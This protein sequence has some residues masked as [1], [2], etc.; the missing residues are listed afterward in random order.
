MKVANGRPGPNIFAG[1]LIREGRTRRV[2]SRIQ[3]A[4]CYQTYLILAFFAN[5]PDRQ[6]TMR[7][8]ELGRSFV[9]VDGH[10]VIKY[11]PNDY[12]TGKVYG[13]RPLLKLPE[14]LTP[15]I[16]HC[17]ENW[18]QRTRQKDESALVAGYDCHP[19]SQPARERTR[20]GIFGPAHGMLGSDSGPILRS[21]DANAKGSARGGAVGINEP[22][23]VIGK[24]RDCA[25]RPRAAPKGPLS[26]S[27]LPQRLSCRQR[28]F[29]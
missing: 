22:S 1:C 13:E 8:L 21:T 18:R 9:K 17:L 28:S 29:W 7:E 11:T 4:K 26:R 25:C 15:N 14:F 6:R 5:I 23:T 24:D 3:V 20:I 2:D 10:W 19:R 27:R 12:K 16:D